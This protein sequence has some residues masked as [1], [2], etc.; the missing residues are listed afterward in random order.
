MIIII[1]FFIKSNRILN[2]SVEL[3]KKIY[4]ADFQ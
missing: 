4:H 1:F 3:E 2:F